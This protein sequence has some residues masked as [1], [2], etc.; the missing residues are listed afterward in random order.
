MSDNKLIAII[1]IGGFSVMICGLFFGGEGVM[2]SESTKKFKE[3][4]K[5]KQ[6][7]YKAEQLKLQWKIDSTKAA[8][9]NK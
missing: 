1:V 7:Q 2:D 3:T 6:E 9:Q 4:E 5:T 8:Q